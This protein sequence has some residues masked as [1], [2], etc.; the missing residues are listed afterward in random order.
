MPSASYIRKRK[1]LAQ[2]KS[3]LGVAARERKRVERAEEM[4]VVAEVRTSG[5]LGKHHIELLDCGHR[6][7]RTT[8]K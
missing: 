5:S 4:R 8:V 2:R 6:L 1:E 3:A 7:T